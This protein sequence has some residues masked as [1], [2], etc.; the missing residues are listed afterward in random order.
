MKHENI[1]LMVCVLIVGLI[2][3]YCGHRPEPSLLP[4]PD[5]TITYEYRDTIIKFD[6]VLKS[7]I[8]LKYKYIYLKDTSNTTFLDCDT[9]T[10]ETTPIIIDSNFLFFNINIISK[11]MIKRFDYSYKLKDQKI[12]LTTEKITIKEPYP[13]DVDPKYWKIYA[14]GIFRSDDR[15]KINPG[16]LLT[17]DRLGVSA[18]YDFQYKNI[19]IGAYYLIFK[20]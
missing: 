4:K 1:I 20:F 15:F 9:F 13:V 8:K 3:G 17:K 14:G 11:G 6:T 16:I 12:R 5:T 10:R 7:N 2:I 19:N 18:G